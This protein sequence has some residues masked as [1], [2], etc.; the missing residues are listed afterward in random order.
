MERG[1]ELELV[2]VVVEAEVEPE[3]GVAELNYTE[4]FLGESPDYSVPNLYNRR[5]ES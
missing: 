3:F 4:G 5:G 1:Y 2:L